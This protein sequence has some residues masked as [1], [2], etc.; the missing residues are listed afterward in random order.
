MRGDENKLASV[1]IVVENPVIRTGFFAGVILAAVMVGSL[2][3]ATR[4]PKFDSIAALRNLVSFAAF[5]LAMAIPVARYF[6]SPWRMFTAGM[7]AWSLLSAAYACAAIF[8]DNLVN[9]L[10][11]TPLHLLIL[12]AVIYGVLAAMIWVASSVASLLWRSAS[13]TDATAFEM[14]TRKQ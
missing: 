8:F 12:G 11:M 7:T 4:V 1:R 5:G 2:V 6:G 14:T 9:R 10:G 13:E 3:A